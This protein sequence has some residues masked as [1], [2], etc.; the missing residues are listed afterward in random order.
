MNDK[1]SIMN[2]IIIDKKKYVLIPQKNYHALQKMATLTVKSN[3]DKILT[4]DQARNYSKK[5][6]RKYTEE[7]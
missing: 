4:L 7:K 6:I 3:R 5:M 2:E 1:L